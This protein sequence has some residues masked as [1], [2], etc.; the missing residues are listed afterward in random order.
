MKYWI[1]NTFPKTIWPLWLK[2]KIQIRPKESLYGNITKKAEVFYKFLWLH[3]LRGKV[4]NDI[5]FYKKNGTWEN[6]LRVK[7]RK[8]T[9]NVDRRIAKIS[10][11]DPFLP[12]TQIR[13][14]MVADYAVNVSPQ[15][16]R[17]LLNEFGLYERIAPKKKHCCPFKI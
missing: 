14:Q 13:G 2:I 7:P 10:K 4:R 3:F 17:K 16:I 9:L 5:A 15:T 1:L 11:T 6:I 12:S 8:T